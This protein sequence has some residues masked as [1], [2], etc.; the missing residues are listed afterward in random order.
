MVP[1]FSV[2]QYVRNKNRIP[3]GV[4]VAL[5]DENH[6]QKYR[7]GYSMCCKNDRFSKRKALEIAIGRAN[8]NCNIDVDSLPHDVRK[9]FPSFYNRCKRYYK[10]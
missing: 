4:L 10:S 5:K 3:Y 6:H 9:M 7:I 2:V 8:T 1:R